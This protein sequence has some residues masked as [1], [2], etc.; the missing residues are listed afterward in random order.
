MDRPSKLNEVSLVSANFGNGLAYKDVLMDWFRFLGGKPG[1]VV[2]VDGGSDI[3][4][5]TVYW[6]LYKAGLIDKLQVI[7]SNH[8]ENNKETCY[9]QEYTVGAIAS[10]P[11]LLWFKI[12]TLPYR[13]GHDNWL[14]EAINYLDRDDVFAVGGAFNRAWEH[15]EAW[16][17][18][19]FCGAC[20]INFCLMKRS[21]FIATMQEFA[22]SYIDCGF[23][24][25]HPF[26]RF[27]VEKAFIEYMAAHK[28][29]TLCKIEDPTWTIFHTNA[30]NKDLQTIRQRYLEREDV[31]RYINPALSKD[32]TQFLYYGKPPENAGIVKQLQ[33]AFGQTSI[34]FYWR[35]FKHRVLSGKR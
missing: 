29:Y 15:R 25:E 31:E 20:T 11:Y 19:Y 12:D 2:V 9:I 23:K 22:G 28:V 17:G 4:T 8:E 16:P 7:Q 32:V 27:L 34:G 30:Q 21:T 5:Q 26:G 10:K 33:I 14:E 13:E 24:G 6:E 1:E 18:W 35:R 3:S